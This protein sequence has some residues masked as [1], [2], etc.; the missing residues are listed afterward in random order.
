MHAF[1]EKARSDL[2]FSLHAD[3]HWAYTGQ[4]SGVEGLQIEFEFLAVGNEFVPKV[5]GVTKFDPVWVASL[6]DIAV[7]KASAYQNRDEDRDHEDLLYILGEMMRAGQT[8][9][10]YGIEENEIA[11]IRLVLSGDLRF[12]QVTG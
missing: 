4:G 2:R 12:A 1:E 9:R 7:M 10:H 8:L 11:V 6:A 3:G 5:W